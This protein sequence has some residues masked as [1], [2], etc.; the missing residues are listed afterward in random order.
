M[1][2]RPPML[3]R[4]WRP[5]DDSGTPAYYANQND[6][7]AAVI[8]IS[9]GWRRTAEGWAAAGYSGASWHYYN[10]LDGQILRQLDHR[11]GGYHAG[12]G[13]RRPNGT[14]NPE[15]TWPLWR[16]WNSNVN[17]YTVGIENEG[18]GPLTVPQQRSLKWL[19]QWLADVEGFPYDR[20]HFPA[21]AD[22]ALIDR[23]NDFGILADR[24]AIYRYLFE[25]GDPEMK[26]SE[27]GLMLL[28][29]GDFNNMTIAYTA[30][31]ARGFF[32]TLV[33]VDGPA[34]PIDGENDLND[35]IVRRFR[36]QWLALSDAADAAWAF[37]QNPG[38]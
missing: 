22:I 19:C 17:L 18:F 35:A 16:G 27:R 11:H 8:H 4:L 30:L 9:V 31:E 24:E 14:N 13:R 21:H 36:L 1:I 20:D 29:S 10:C 3:D 38:V 12:I 15:P 7:I 32:A 33:A 25:Q 5:T 28:S 34:A 2:E 37:I 23:P 26:P 6:P